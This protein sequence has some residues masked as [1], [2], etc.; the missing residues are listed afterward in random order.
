MRLFK[1]HEVLLSLAVG[2]LV[3]A[4]GIAQVLYGSLTGTITDPS[5]AAVPG[6]KLQILNIDTGI[7]NSALTN[8]RGT[9]LVSDLQPGSYKVTFAASGFAP[10]VQSGVSIVQN[11]IRRV[12]VQLVLASAGQNITV[13][14]ETLALQTDRANVSN[15]ISSTQ[16]ANLP[17]G[18]GRSFQNVL[19]SLPGFST[20]GGGTPSSSGN[21]AGAQ[22]YYVNGATQFGNNT[23]V[24]GASDIYPWQPQYVMQIPP[25]ESIEA[26]SVVTNSFDAEQGAAAGA[27]VNVTLKSGTNQF[28]GALWEYHTNSELKARNFFYYGGKNPK[29][30]LNQYGLNLGGPVKK[31]KLFFF[32]DWERYDQRTLY[33]GFQTVATDA[34][35]QGDFS[36]TGTTIYDPNTGLS[37]GTGRTPFPNNKIPGSAMSSAALKMVSLLPAPNQPGGIPNDYFYAANWS[38]TRNNVDAKVNYNPTD[39]TAIF[40]RYGVAPHNITDPQT[41]G[42]AG[43]AGVDGSTFGNG[44][45]RTQHVSIGGNHTITPHIIFDGNA[46]FSRLH[47]SVLTFDYGKNYGT[48]LLAIPGTNGPSPLQGG[49]PQFSFTGFSTI[50]DANSS[51]PLVFRDNLWVETAN[52]SW[53]KGAHNFRFGAEFVHILMADYQANSTVGV[54]GGFSFSGGMS[55]L[56]GGSAPN[57]YNSWADFLLG[58]PSAMNKDIQYIDPAVVAENELFFYARDQWQVNRKL[59]FSYGLRYEYY[60]YSHGEHGIGGIHY[61]PTTN[62]VYLGGI[63]GVPGDAGVDTGHGLWAPRGGLAYRVDNKTVVRLGFGININPETFRNN[64]Q[65]YPDVVSLQYSGPNSFTPAGSLVTGIPVFVGPNLGAG[66]IPLPANVGSWTYPSPFRRG[67]AESYN[68]TVQRD[69]GAGFNIQAGYVGNRDIRPESGVDI[70]A[71]S[72]GLGTKGQPYYLLW[73]NPSR[74]S[75][76]LPLDN[77]RYNSLQMRL[78]HRTSAGTLGLNYTFSKTLDA[79]D[80]ETGGS[81]TWNWGPMQY[82]NYGLAGFDRTHNF[83]ATY[84]YSLPFGKGQN[85]LKTGIPAILAGGWQVNGILSRASGTP[86]T[87]SSSATSLNAPS[88]TQ[89]ADQVV[90]SVQILG[91]HGPGS[92][93]FDPNA[94]LPVTAV[95]FG[96][97][98]RNI[99]RG[100]GLFNLDCSVFRSFAIRERF[101]LQFRVEAFGLTNTATFG[102]P[103]TT[104]SNATFANGVATN[105]NGYDIISSSTGERQV[106]M[107]LRFTF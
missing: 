104:V 95:R 62:L 24:D 90:S 18:G 8:E 4:M 37:N 2:L 28:H 38:Y 101:N 6:A 22:S 15:E 31:N 78:T 72:P 56:S 80:N 68:F 11:T 58:L 107:A 16:T 20:A 84:V 13:S 19:R 51:T 30:I 103:G 100:P 49:Y 1:N 79:A 87:I 64:I 86:F 48:D 40:V 36:G 70:N 91:G 96:N 98:G 57:L 52:L 29:N 23:K 17:L 35:K 105:L 45:G 102:N 21:P 66:K 34:L 59:T 73:G 89:T 55:A 63:N 93:Y 46:G 71:G 83:Q 43:G 12:D 25:A 67:Y 60:P 61:D 9:Y 26:V 7:S 92:P 47:L 74:I 99:I 32:A 41:L 82:R 77:T 53:V 39:R 88:N 76:L 75:A 44:S 81:L 33:S 54:R 94:F 27:A 10:A 5:G 106:R 42:A 3:P 14:A 85:W 65:T 69:L 50:G 97:S